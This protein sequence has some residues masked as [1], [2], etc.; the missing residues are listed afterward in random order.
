VKDGEHL[1]DYI[2]HRAEIVDAI[3]SDTPQIEHD[4]ETGLGDGAPTRD[5]SAALNDVQSRIT[6]VLGPSVVN[7]QEWAL[8]PGEHAPHGVRSGLSPLRLA[9]RSTS[10]R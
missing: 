1:Q 3:Q 7:E 5:L 8:G 2:E 6:A 9:S 10:K 4:F